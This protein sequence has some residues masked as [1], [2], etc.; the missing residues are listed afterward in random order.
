[1][2]SALP[3]LPIF[4]IELRYCPSGKS[5]YCSSPQCCSHDL[6]SIALAPARGRSACFMTGRNVSSSKV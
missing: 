6:K 3:L 2:V 1:M 4:G 5:L